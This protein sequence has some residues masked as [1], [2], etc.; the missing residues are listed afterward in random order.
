MNFEK[1]F[2]TVTTTQ[3]ALQGHKR[4]RV[5]LY[6]HTHLGGNEQKRNLPIYAGLGIRTSK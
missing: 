2:C 1:F 4:K 5:P 3:S 6:M